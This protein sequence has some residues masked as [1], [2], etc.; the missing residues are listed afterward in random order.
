MIID[1][2]I[3]IAALVVPFLIVADPGVPTWAYRKIRNKWK[4]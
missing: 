3:C 2:L 1:I 4:R